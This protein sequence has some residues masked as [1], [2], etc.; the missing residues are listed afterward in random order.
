MNL[1]FLKQFVNQSIVGYGVEAI[2]YLSHPFLEK[3]NPSK[4]FI[5]FNSGRAGSTL[6]VKLLDNHSQ[7]QCEGEILRRK[8]LYPRAYINRLCETSGAGSLWL[9]TLVLPITKC[10]NQY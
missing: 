4:K 8:M 7:I 1:N 6:L 5:V 2:S 9:Q 10:S 3:K